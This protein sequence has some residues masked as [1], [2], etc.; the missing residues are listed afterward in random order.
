MSD[1]LTSEILML[2]NEVICFAF[3]YIV[4]QYL[5]EEI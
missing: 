3:I 4:S 5:K 1:F 2:P